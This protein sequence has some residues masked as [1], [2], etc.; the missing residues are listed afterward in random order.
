MKTAFEPNSILQPTSVGGPPALPGAFPLYGN[1]RTLHPRK[2]QPMK[3][4]MKSPTSEQAF[5]RLELAMLLATLVLLGAIALPVLGGNKP[6]SEQA[7]CFSNLRQIGHA[8]HLW[9]NDHGDRNPWI[10]P[11][12]EGGTLFIANGLKNKAFFQMA[13]ISNELVTPRILVCPS[14]RGVGWPRG[15]ATDFSRTN[16][17]GGF[18]AVSFQDNALS[19]IIGLHS[20]Y[21]MPRSVLSGDRNLKYESQDSTCSTGVG[22]AWGINNPTFS[23]VWTNSIHFNAGNLLFTDGGVEQLSSPGLLRALNAPNQDQYYEHHFLAPN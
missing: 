2:T 22:S 5:T 21:E 3:G 17:N 6:R 11:T 19:Y 13:W 10:T 9:A 18:L 1:H 15:I 20:S 23:A 4:K 7:I 14:D 16:V 8:F 12:A